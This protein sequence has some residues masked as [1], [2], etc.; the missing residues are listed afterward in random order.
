MADRGLFGN[1]TDTMMSPLFM[2]GAGLL[3][4]GGMSGMLQGMQAGTQYQD[5][6]RQRQREDATREAVYRMPGALTM[7]D[8]E[9]LASNPQMATQVLGN[10]VANRLDPQAKMK[11]DLMRSQIAHS[12]V[13]NQVAMA[14]LQQMKMQTP[15]F[16]AGM[17]GKYGLQPGTPEYN[18]FVLNGTY[19]PRDPM[20]GFISEMIKRQTQPQASAAP[21]G[22]VQPQSFEG[23]VMPG[24]VTPVADT[25]KPTGTTG[26]SLFG[27][28]PP[29]Q[30]RSMAEMM[31]LNPKTKAMGEQ[32][33][34]DLEQGQLGKEGRNEVD[35]KLLASGEGLARLNTIQSGFRPEYMTIENRLGFAWNAAKEKYLG[36]RANLN[37]Q[38]KAEL[39]AF[40]GFKA[41]ALDNVNQYIKE[42]T[43]AAMTDAEAKRIMAGMPNVGAGVFDGDSPTEFKSKMDAV[44]NR[45]KLAHARWNYAQ[46]TGQSWTSI[47]LHQMGSVVQQRTNE[48]Q[49]RYQ[50]QGLQGDD[51]RSAVQRDLRRDFGI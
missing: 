28:L 4:G 32:L 49:G 16:R 6:Q 17:A 51:L 26:G 18:A 25:A 47:G 10:A 37:P 48:L 23:G 2:G 30:K 5:Q 43:G 50:Q 42:I 12:G 24:G 20:E 22:G 3:T 1:I 19:Q 29:E 44:I 9:L 35:K 46:K 34:K 21:Q 27:G 33:I 36:G 11:L 41:D 14:Q 13:Q 40:T 15:E 38:Q 8:R 7:A 31:L 39:E 45:L